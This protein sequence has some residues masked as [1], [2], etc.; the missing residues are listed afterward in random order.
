[1]FLSLILS[2]LRLHLGSPKITYKKIFTNKIYSK[3]KKLF[4]FI[5]FDTSKSYVFKQWG[6]ADSKLKDTRSTII[7]VFSLNR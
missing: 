1:M 7:L 5:T 6:I 4:K 2:G 3:P